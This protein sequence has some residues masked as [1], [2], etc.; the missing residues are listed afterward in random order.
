MAPGGERY[1]LPDL[2][3]LKSVDYEHVYEPGEVLLWD[4]L[5]ILHKAGGGFGDRPRLLLRTQTMYAPS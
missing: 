5:Q 3:H 4:N 2:S 1:A